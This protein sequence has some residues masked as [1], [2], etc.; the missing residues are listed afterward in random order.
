MD[1]VDRKRGTVQRLNIVPK[2][3]TQGLYSWAM[4]P[5]RYI[6]IAPEVRPRIKARLLTANITNMGNPT[7]T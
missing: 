1:L 7:I 3:M 4:Y 2:N 5:K 6:L